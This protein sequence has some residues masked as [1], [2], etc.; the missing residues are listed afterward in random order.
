MHRFLVR[1]LV[2]GALAVMTFAAPVATV[3]ACSCMQMDPAAAVDMAE[4]AFVGT[5]VDTATAEKE[6]GTGMSLV[7]YAF[8]VERASQASG[9]IVEVSAIDG[10]GGASCGFAFGMDERWFVAATTEEGSLRTTLCSGNLMIEDLGEAE[11]AS[12]ANLLP[13]EPASAAPTPDPAPEATPTVAG[14]GVPVAVA[15]LIGAA[16]AAALGLVLVLAMRRGRAI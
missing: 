10:D 8:E 7:R 13:V 3:N 14:V 9:P 2:A 16:A 11:Q 1:G 5:V 6:A 15:L 12:L 4:L